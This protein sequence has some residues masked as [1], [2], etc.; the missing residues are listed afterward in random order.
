MGSQGEAGAVTL[1]FPGFWDRWGDA[2][3]GWEEMGDGQGA[4]RGVAGQEDLR[5]ST[6]SARKLQTGPPQKTRP[7]EVTL[8]EPAGLN[9]WVELSHK[10]LAKALVI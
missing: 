5:N 7:A 3:G 2:Q 10:M 8:G 9:L 1:V 6:C 4:G